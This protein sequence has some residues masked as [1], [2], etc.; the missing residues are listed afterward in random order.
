MELVQEGNGKTDG[1]WAGKVER[2][3]KHRTTEGRKAKEKMDR[4]ENCRVQLL[5]F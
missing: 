1:Q 5:R 2:E 3:Q 4:K